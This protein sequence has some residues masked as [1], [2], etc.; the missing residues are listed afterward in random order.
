MGW[1]RMIW[2]RGPWGKE[3]GISLK[4]VRPNTHSR[5]DNNGWKR[6]IA[7]GRKIYAGDK[8]KTHVLVQQ[9]AEKDEHEVAECSKYKSIVYLL[10][11]TV[12]AFL[13]SEDRPHAFTQKYNRVRSGHPGHG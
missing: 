5:K 13:L 7:C 12:F 6:I 10:S 3:I 11:V 9:E 4:F 1:V 2:R 8:F